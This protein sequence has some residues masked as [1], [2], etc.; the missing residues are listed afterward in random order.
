M[1]GNKTLAAIL[2]TALS[3]VVLASTGCTKVITAPAGS[4]ANTVTASGMGTVQATPDIAEMS[5][6]VSTQSSN[7]KTALDDA[8]KVAEKI[9]AALKKA[10][11]KD[12][13]I[14]TRDV[15]VYPQYGDSGGSQTVTGYQA[16]VTVTAKVRDIGTLGDVITAANQAGANSIN[17]PTFTVADQAP[18]RAKAIEKAVADAR[19]SAEAMA[20]AAG[21]SVGAVLSVSSSDV[22][23]VPGPVFATAESAGAAKSV[24]IEAGQ[25]DITSTVTVIF[26]LK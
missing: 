10:G 13:D 4:A 24:P 16:S 12:E 25:L 6:G 22:S 21:K 2:I 11:V 18:H 20:K 3:L 17:G 15:N 19:K 26:E 8:S 23:V 5:F 9:T 7:A 14:Q 1:K